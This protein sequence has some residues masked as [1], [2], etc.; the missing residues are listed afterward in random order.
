LNEHIRLDVVA[1]GGFRAEFGEVFCY[2]GIGFEAFGVARTAEEF[3][4]GG[5]GI[6]T[7]IGFCFGVP[8][9]TGQRIGLPSGPL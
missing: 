2:A 3:P 6:G 5:V 7:A 1:L 4:V 9:G 8:S